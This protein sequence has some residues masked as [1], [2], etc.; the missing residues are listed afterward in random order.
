MEKIHDTRVSW[1]I[2]GV[3][4]CHTFQTTEKKTTNTGFKNP[5]QK[6]N[7]D[8]K[9]SSKFLTNSRRHHELKKWIY[10]ASNKLSLKVHVFLKIPLRFT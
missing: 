5:K 9:L 3:K 1:E 8:A 10:F 2:S 7:I 6:C 4:N